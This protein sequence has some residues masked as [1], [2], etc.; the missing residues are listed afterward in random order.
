[1]YILFNKTYHDH[2][3]TNPNPRSDHKIQRIYMYNLKKGGLQIE[4]QF[5]RMWFTLLFTGFVILPFGIPDSGLLSIVIT[6][7]K[8]RTTY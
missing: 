8:K 3:V 7:V 4:A 5:K 1:M 2:N 6:W